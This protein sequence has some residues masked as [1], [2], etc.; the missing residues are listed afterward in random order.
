VTA[1]QAEETEADFTPDP[2]VP[3]PPG[4]PRIGDT[5]SLGREKVRGW[6]AGGLLGLL[7]LLDAALFY[8]ALQISPFDRDLLALLLTGLLN[9]G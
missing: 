1:P 7:L 6:L 9:P 4:G 8:A 2:E 5:I 3:P